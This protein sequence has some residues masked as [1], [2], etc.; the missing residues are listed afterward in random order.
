M[1]NIRVGKSTIISS[2]V[3]SKKVDY[4]KIEYLG[5]IHV[6]R[7]SAYSLILP[8]A[9]VFHKSYLWNVSRIWTVHFSC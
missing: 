1:I 8:S 7:Q 9:A 6:W 2:T 5:P 4:K 3:E